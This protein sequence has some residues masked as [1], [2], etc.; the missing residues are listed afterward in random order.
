[1]EE[2]STGGKPISIGVI[3]AAAMAGEI[4]EARFKALQFIPC[5]NLVS[6]THSQACSDNVN[7]LCYVLMSTGFVRHASNQQTEFI[8]L[9]PIDIRLQSK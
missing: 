7:T 8:M 6:F 9:T 4:I 3:D 1:M 5:S 2:E